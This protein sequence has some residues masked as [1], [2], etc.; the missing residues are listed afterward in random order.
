MVGWGRGRVVGLGLRV[1]GNTLVFHISNIAV[2]ASAVG[3]NLDTAVGKVDPVLS[4]GVVVGTVLLVGEDSSGVGGVVNS[5]SVLQ[6][7]RG[8]RCEGEKMFYS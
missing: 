7:W 5:K 1:L 8:V 3:D 6:D 2:W 4:L